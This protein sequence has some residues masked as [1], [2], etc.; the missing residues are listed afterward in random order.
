L[1]KLDDLEEMDK[2]LEPYTL[3]RLNDETGADSFT[4]PFYQTFKDLTLSFSNSF[5]KLKRKKRFLT[6]FMRP[7][8]L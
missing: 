4:G 1:N 8:S 5:Q 7:T 2:F 3:P 6:H